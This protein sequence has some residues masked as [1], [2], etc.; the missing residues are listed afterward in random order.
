MKISVLVSGAVLVLCVVA[1]A[2][3]LAWDH[4]G[5]GGWRG[6]RHFSRYNNTVI[7]AQPISRV[8]Y[9]QPNYYEPAVQT[10]RVNCDSGFN[11]VT[12]ILGGALG[13]VAGNGIGRGHG[14]TAAIITGAVLGTT[15][16]GN[17]G[18]TRCSEQVVYQAPQVVQAGNQQQTSNN[19]TYGRYCREYQNR[20]TVG[21]RV[22]ETYGTACMQPDGSWEI[23]N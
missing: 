22:Q 4:Y 15:I 23:V 14:R 10:T 1:S 21:G 7:Y 12:G 9:L 20:S 8:S 11:P 5:H 2:P 19:N 13:G 6:D 16:G 17:V 18:Q 3:A